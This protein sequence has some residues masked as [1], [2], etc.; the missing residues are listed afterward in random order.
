QGRVLPGAQHFGAVALRGV[1]NAVVQGRVADGRPGG[2]HALA[3]GPQVPDVQRQSRLGRALRGDENVT[4]CR[5]E[6][7]VSGQISRSHYLPISY[8]KAGEDEEVGGLI[9]AAPEWRFGR[10]PGT[11]LRQGAWRTGRR[12]R[13]QGR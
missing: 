3:Q 9:S 8:L 11:L 4:R 5:Y 2:A 12:T 1:V 6:H 7:G 13:S 10:S